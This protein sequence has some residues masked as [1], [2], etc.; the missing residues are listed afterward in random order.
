M[1]SDKISSIEEPAVTVE[2][3]V[4]EGERRRRETL[5]FSSHR[6]DQLIETLDSAQQV[7]FLA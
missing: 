4:R 6:L 1:G 3:D 5:E 7:L 2:L